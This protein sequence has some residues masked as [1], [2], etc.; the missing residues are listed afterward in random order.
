MKSKW[1]AGIL[2]SCLIASHCLGQEQKPQTNPVLAEADRLQQAGN[3]GEAIAKY[4]E[5]LKAEPN[6]APAQAGLIRAYLRDEQTGAAYDLATTALAAQPNSAMLLSAMGFVRYRRGEITEAEKSFLAARKVD[7]NLADAYLGLNRVYRT[8]LLY[9][10]AYD[11]VQKAHLIAPG[12]PAVQ[13]AWMSLLPRSE[14]IKA[15]E[16][17]LGAPHPENREENANLQAWL[18][19]LKATAGQPVHACKL[20]N[21]VTATETPLHAML[22]DPKHMNGYG[23]VVKLND[24]SQRLL[25][26]T[27]AGGITINRR[28]AERAGLKRISKFEFG[29]IGDKGNREAYFALVDSIHVGELEFKD[30]VVTVTEKSMGL[31]ED[32]LI[33]A[34]VFSSYVVDV[35][36]PAEKLRLT[37]LPKRPEDKEEKASLSSEAASD[38]DDE[39]EGSESKPT[40]EEGKGG[41][42]KQLAPQIPK[43]RYVAP[44]MVKW[45]RVFRIGHDLLIPTKVNDSKSM[46]FI[47]DT[48]AF[49][50]TM[51]AAAAREVTKVRGD[52][53]IRVKGLSG[54][55][56][57]VYSA[58]DVML[59][60]GNMRQPNKDLVTFDFSNISRNLGVEVSGFLGF[61]TFR[62]VEMKID[63]R[64]GLVEFI[65]DPS[66]LPPALRPR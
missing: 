10:M 18:N 38:A 55:V 33:G 51:S 8:A 19:Y 15:L 58:D 42:D 4:R 12:D 61:A 30:C 39:T 35:D 40:A 32:G 62:V 21:A 45:A 52:D 27:G 5:V 26:D 44:E 9:R 1:L 47:L 56:N 64:D 14:R 6:L 24:H 25:L 23:L 3:L 36:F 20:A 46:L 65:Y 41:A 22:R 29:G 60:F 49:S 37:P 43:D 31:D 16:A 11:Q 57:K 34:D 54:E 53:T 13:R 66:K 17:Y 63:Y 48:G 28:A 2:A 7:P 59:Q 50:N